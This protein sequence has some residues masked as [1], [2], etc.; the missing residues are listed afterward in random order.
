MA[1]RRPGS[2]RLLPSVAVEPLETHTDEHVRWLTFRRPE[3]L[4]SFTAADYRDLRVA[5]DTAAED[6]DVRVVVIT[7]TGRSFSAGADRSLLTGSG[8]DTGL[9]TGSEFAQFVDSLTSFPKPLLAAVNGLAVGVGTTM[10]LHCDLVIASSSARFRMPFAEI[11]IV[12]E[13][14][15]TALLPARMR[16]HDVMWLVM[17]GEWLDVAA[18]RDVGLVWRIVEDDGFAAEVTA[19]AHSLAR[20]EPAVATATKKLLVDGRRDG[21][22]AALDRE[23]AAMVTLAEARSGTRSASTQSGIGSSATTS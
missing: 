12:P 1:D 19:V 15:S 23:M 10:L 17:S 7:G 2:I 4:N 6:S 14:G 3:R 9:D 16:W 22:R 21:I 8:D 20:A 5:L 11:G 18:A 13:A